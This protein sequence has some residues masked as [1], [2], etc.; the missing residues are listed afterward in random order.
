M[1]EAK[2]KLDG[3]QP[4]LWEGGCKTIWL[5]DTDET[6]AMVLLA[7][8]ETKPTAKATA[9]A[10]DSLLRAHGC[11]GFPYPRAHGPAIAALAL[12]FGQGAQ[13]ATDMEMGVVV[14]GTA[15]GTVKTVGTLGQHVLPVPADIAQGGSEPGRV[16]DERPRPIHLRRHA[17]RL[18]ART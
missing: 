1:L 10:A 12:W 5:N 11:F 3:N 15:I 17:V 14:N 18:L 9:A 8:A 7:L 6:T 16:Q 13:Q 2:V 4:V